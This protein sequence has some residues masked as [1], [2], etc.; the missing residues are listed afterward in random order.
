MRNGVCA[1]LEA[2]HWGGEE[3]ARELLWPMALLLPLR[4][5]TRHPREA[6]S[7]ASNILGRNLRYIYLRLK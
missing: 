5:R 3:L 7:E 6:F 1:L 2:T 4:V